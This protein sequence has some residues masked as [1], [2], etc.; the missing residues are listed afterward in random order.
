[1]DERTPWVKI[2]RDELY[3][4]FPSL[5]N[6]SLKDM[7]QLVSMCFQTNSDG[8][9]IYAIKCYTH[10]YPELIKEE[11]FNKIMV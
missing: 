8:D 7:V 2:T 3:E 11:N 6:L 10:S 9:L 1:M 5:K 4:K